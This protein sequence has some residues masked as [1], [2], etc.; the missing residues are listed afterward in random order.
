ML[1]RQ[2]TCPSDDKVEESHLSSAFDITRRAWEVRVHFPIQTAVL[3]PVAA[4]VWCPLY[5]LWL[6]AAG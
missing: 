2:L 1:F 4:T 5:V 3:T 6:S